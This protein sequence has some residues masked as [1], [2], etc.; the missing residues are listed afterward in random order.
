V[1]KLFPFLLAASLAVNAALALAY[2][3]G[4]ATSKPAAPAVA[5]SATSAKPALPKVDA[6]VWPSLQTADL[7]DL[8]SRLRAAGF[9]PDIIR[10][11]LA[12]QISEGFAARRKA[13]V[14]DADNLPFWKTFRPDPKTEIALRQLYREEQKTLR[15]LLGP[16]PD[17]NDPLNQVEQGRRLDGLPREKVGEISRILDDY[18]EKRSDIYSAGTYSADREKIAALDKQQHAAL[19]ALLTPQELEEYDLRNSD[20]AHSLRTDLA[21]FNSTEQEFRAIFR[22]QQAFDEK[23]GSFP[24]ILPPDQ[25]RQR[26]DAETQLTEQIKA[27]LAPDRAAIYDRSTDSRYLQTSQLIARLELPPETTDSLW[28]IQQDFQQRRA[29][30]STGIPRAER[31]AQLTALAAEAQTKITTLL[32]P[33]GLTAYKQYGGQWLTSMVPRAAPPAAPR[34]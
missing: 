1:K 3:L 18:D 16:E 30:V 7:S 5:A 29:A 28:T 4:P 13:L 22:L 17:A 31:M 26:D 9:P 14:S 24:G 23:F 34:P 10:A 8:V 2:L 32:G 33:A 11:M 21:A 6:S 20:T 25:M 15:A 27:A 12:A 19:A